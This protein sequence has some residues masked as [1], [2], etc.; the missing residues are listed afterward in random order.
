[1]KKNMLR[2]MMLLLLGVVTS[3]SIH[4]QYGFGTS[5]PHSSTVMDMT[6]A[7]KGVLF[8]R[9]SLANTGD[10]TPIP[11]PA[12]HLMV[13]NMNTTTD[14]TH[15]Y[16]PTN[17]T[18]GLYSWNG[19]AWVR[20]LTLDGPVG[21]NVAAPQTSA[22]LDVT[23]SDKGM[24]LPRMTSAQIRQIQNPV[25]G[26]LVYNTDQQCL[27]YYVYNNFKCVFAA[28][29]TAGSTVEANNV[30]PVY[31]SV[32]NTVSTFT[33]TV[34][35]SN[36][37]DS[38][39]DVD[40]GTP[41]Y[42]WY[43]YSDNN[44]AGETAIAGANTATYTL[45]ANDG[46][47]YIRAGVQAVAKT[48]TT[49]G[50]MQFASYL[51]P[52]WVCGMDLT[53]THTAGAVA[54]VN[55]EVIYKTVPTNIGGSGVKCWITKNLGA[56]QQASPST[57]T[58]EPSNGWYWQFNR[59]QGYKYDGSTITPNTQLGIYTENSDW[60][61]GNDPC[62]LLLG[63]GWRI[64]KY[65]E[66]TSAANAWNGGLGAAYAS[67]LKLHLSGWGSV[68]SSVGVYGYFWSSQQQAVGQGQS[69]QI[70]T[71]ASVASGSWGK[72]NAFALRCLKD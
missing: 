50:D 25:E 23:S 27:M 61:I 30:A 63:A 70:S 60:L 53:V 46:G 17:V 1:M 19:T 14:L 15:T 66:W 51:G 11:Q 3:T 16:S 4:A 28:P 36:Y 33:A 9:V 29:S 7:N 59:Q 22:V 2:T 55:K 67:V 41:I 39:N 6:S 10:L 45:T 34:N 40:A 43:R 24:L 38:E 62:A 18:P 32:T 21:V 54:P 71:T 26:L 52:L 42:Q 5:S 44:G 8:P 56:D 13:F 57:A 49:S 58:D 72:A 69:M 20:L 48:G 47:K 37:N 31:T 65:A 64:P 68:G 12:L 35:A